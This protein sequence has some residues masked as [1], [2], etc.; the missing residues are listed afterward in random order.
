MRR[1]PQ[2]NQEIP[3]PS[4]SYARH[5]WPF[6]DLATPRQGLDLDDTCVAPSSARGYDFRDCGIQRRYPSSSLIKRNRAARIADLITSVACY[7]QGGSPGFTA[8]RERR[9]NSI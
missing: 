7:N 5:N 4:Q 3:E 8:P 1:I 6:G 2:S 9:R